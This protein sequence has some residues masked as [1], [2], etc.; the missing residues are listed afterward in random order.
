M[1]F[2]YEFSKIFHR[3]KSDQTA[4]GETKWPD[5]WLFYGWLGQKRFFVAGGVPNTINEL[6]D[7]RNV[8]FVKTWSYSELQK[9]KKAREQDSFSYN[10][11]FDIEKYDSKQQ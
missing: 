4:I 6:L 7:R 3:V 2:H 1:Q 10:M 11:N 8:L 5:N 9:L